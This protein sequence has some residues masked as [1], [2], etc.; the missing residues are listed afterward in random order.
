LTKQRETARKNKDWAQSDTLRK[1]IEAAG[2]SIDD[3]IEGT[4]IR[5][6]CCIINL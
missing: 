1:E 6:L 4:R 3:T 5:M 2:Y